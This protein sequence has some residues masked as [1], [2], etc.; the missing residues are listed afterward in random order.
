MT[1]NYVFCVY[2]GKSNVDEY[3]ETATTLPE[4]ILVFDHKG[5]P[6][7]KFHTDKDIIRVAVSEDEKTMYCISVDP[8]VEI[9]YYDI[10]N[11]LR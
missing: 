4:T 7:K 10:S 3:G 5:N 9:I 11:Q 1:K 6:I 2:S 8:E